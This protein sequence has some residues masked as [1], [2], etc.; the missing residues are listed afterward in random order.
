L[1][2]CFWVDAVQ[3]VSAF[4]QY[5]LNVAVAWFLIAPGGR[6]GFESLSD[7]V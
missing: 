6:E 7:L 1:M 5:F 4:A 2:L 3:A